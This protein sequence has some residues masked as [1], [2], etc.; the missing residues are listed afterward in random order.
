MTM[1][2]HRI[3]RL[4]CLIGAATAPL[5]AA[6]LCRFISRIAVKHVIPHSGSEQLPSLTR[7]SV[8]GAADGSFPLIAVALF[9]SALVA[10]SGL[11]VLFSR[12]L[13]ADAVTSAFAVVC[14]VGYTI[15]VAL[16]GSTMMALV[17]PFLPMASE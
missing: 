6:F 8:A 9:L 11:Y 14:C 17:I 15:A 7:T 3:V 16:V 2:L 5:L 12:R 13:S 4:V 10:A 1:F